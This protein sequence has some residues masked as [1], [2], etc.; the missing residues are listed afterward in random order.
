M[1][2]LATMPTHPRQARKIEQ[3]TVDFRPDP[4]LYDALMRYLA[5]DP[6]LKGPA[7][8][9]RAL[10]AYLNKEG[11]YNPGSEPGLTIVG[12]NTP[13]PPTKTNRRGSEPEL[14]L[15]RR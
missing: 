14:K 12:Q 4:A 15:H 9:R 10:R 11:F 5:S 1:N 2:N 7:V 13:V 8:L 6:E 3:V